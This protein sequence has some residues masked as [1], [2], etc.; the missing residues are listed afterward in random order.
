MAK[1]MRRAAAAF[2][3]LRVPQAAVH[4]LD[5]VRHILTRPCMPKQA[6][7]LQINLFLAC[8]C[9]RER[10]RRLDCLCFMLGAQCHGVCRSE[11]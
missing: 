1:S 10:G 11:A 8:D 4:L 2:D 5:Q 3:V 6:M 7:T 9:K